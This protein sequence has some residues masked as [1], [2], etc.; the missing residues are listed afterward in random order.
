M[1]LS[2]VFRSQDAVRALIAS[3]HFESLGPSIS[4]EREY[5]RALRELLDDVI[6]ERFLSNEEESDDDIE[7]LQE[8]FFLI[9][10][11]SVFRSLECP[12]DRLRMY[13]I[14][15]LCLKGM[16]VAGDNL[17]DSEAKMDL[18]LKLGD[19]PRFVSIM[20]L[21]CFDHLMVRVF[22]TNAE[23]CSAEQV[24]RFRREL[25]TSLDLSRLHVL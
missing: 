12:P 14:L 16:V 20:Q 5:T 1:T 4:A 10:F 8:H 2:P 22:E 3:G 13:G 25:L 19:G 15:N 23:R 17:F 7:F 24:V 11:D 18:P 9:L 6:S 21:L